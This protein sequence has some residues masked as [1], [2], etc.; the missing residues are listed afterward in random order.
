M[1]GRDLFQVRRKEGRMPRLRRNGQNTET[2]FIICLALALVMEIEKAELPATQICCNAIEQDVKQI[3][4]G[5]ILK[6]GKQ[7]TGL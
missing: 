7:E 4:Q 3:T 1:A 6:Y 2:K 5:V